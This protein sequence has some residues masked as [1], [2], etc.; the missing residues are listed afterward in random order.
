MTDEKE[1][2]KERK[3]FSKHQ[4]LEEDGI[5]GVVKRK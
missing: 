2:E 5:E 1:K 4:K 3:R